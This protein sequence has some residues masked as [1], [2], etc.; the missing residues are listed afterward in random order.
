M[1]TVLHPLFHLILS[2]AYEV[3]SISQVQM[4]ELR[5]KEVK[6]FAQSHGANKQS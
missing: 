3:Q 4:T 2:E 1:P 5:L 6:K